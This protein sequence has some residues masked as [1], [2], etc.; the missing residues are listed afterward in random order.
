[1]SN[2]SRL[3]LQTEQLCSLRVLYYGFLRA[4]FMNIR[5]HTLIEIAVAVNITAAI[6][7]FH[8][9]I[10]PIFRTA[11][12]VPNLV[13]YNITACHPSKTPTRAIL[14]D[15]HC[16]MVVDPFSNSASAVCGQ[17]PG[18]LERIII[19]GNPKLRLDG[20]NYANL[21]N[22]FEKKGKQRV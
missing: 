3:L 15:G 4:G 7:I 19:G 13:V 17:F 9:R 14:G 6:T 20:V 2:L 16:V 11:V 18:L 22:V 5:R 12:V 10:A 21:E 8:P 1:M